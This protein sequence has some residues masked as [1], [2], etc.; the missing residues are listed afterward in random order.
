MSHRFLKYYA[1]LFPLSMVIGSV[2]LYNMIPADDESAKP[3]AE[4]VWHAPNLRWMPD[5]E[6]TRQLR[7]GRDLIANTSHFFGPMGSI[8]KISNGMECQNCHIEAGTRPFGNS[9]GA[10]ASTYPKYRD[11]SGTIESIEYRIN[12]CMERSMNGKKI[13]STGK[14]MQAMVAY[15]KWL[16]KDVPKGVKPRGAGNPELS[17]LDRAADPDNGRSVYVAKCKTCHG[18]NGEGLKKADS[19][20]YF[21]PPLWGPNSY[22]VSAGLFRLTRFA[23]FVKH[24]MP[25]N[26]TPSAPQLSDEEAW[27]VAAF[28]NSQE[29]PE[30]FFIY[31]W[32]NIAKKPVDYPFGPYADN[33]TEVQHKFGPFNMQKKGKP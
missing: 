7:Y 26:A 2:F 19:S 20:G 6:T 1:I 3:D 27:D 14:E 30:K 23:G 22:N 24:N 32:K 15:L 31:D 4:E 8:A 16:G 13:D 5:N 21:Y 33:Y 29:R 9:F 11:R 17:F 12:E 28:V 10:V 18:A 25:Y